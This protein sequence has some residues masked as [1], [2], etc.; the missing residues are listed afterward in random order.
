MLIKYLL[1]FDY[2][3]YKKRE[4]EETNTGV[5]YLDFLKFISIDFFLKQL[6]LFQ[7]IIIVNL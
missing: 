2:F 3:Y 5:Y 7:Y 1:P 6:N 4:N